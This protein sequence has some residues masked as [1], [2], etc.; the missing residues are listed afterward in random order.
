MNIS[1]LIAFEGI[2]G[3][4]KSTLAN[5]LCDYL[6]EIN[7]KVVYNHQPHG[8]GSPIE[9]YNLIKERRERKLEPLTELLLYT[10]D[11][12]ENVYKFI[13]PRLQEGYT[14]IQ[15]RYVLSTIAYQNNISTD[16]IK[17]ITDNTLFPDK[18]LYPKFTIYVSIPIEV[19]INRLIIRYKQDN[20]MDKLDKFKDKTYYN[21][22]YKY[23]NDVKKRYMD[24]ILDD[25]CNNNYL[26]L[27]GEK[28]FD[29][30]L[31]EIIKYYKGII[32]E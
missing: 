4:G 18:R 5:M 17:Y 26:I 7:N 12:V 16:I 31:E 2:D 22:V 29:Y 13:L 23:L 28:S 27:D 20:R 15:D 8:D 24:Y 30:N 19:S 32:C 10:A 1:M 6:K 9:I 3:S 21:D 25:F 14:I 11:R